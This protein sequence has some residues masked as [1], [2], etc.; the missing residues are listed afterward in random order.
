MLR[1]DARVLPLE[2]NVPGVY[3]VTMTSGPTTRSERIRVW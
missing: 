2:I 3:I 1:G